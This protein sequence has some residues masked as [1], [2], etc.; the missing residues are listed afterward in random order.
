MKD[1]QIRLCTDNDYAS[2]FELLRQ[3]WNKQLNYEMLQSVYNNALKSDSQ[4]LIVCLVDNKVT[5]FCSLTIKNN[6]WQAGNLGHIDE[7]IV[8]KNHRRQGI[9]RKL[10][11]EI[12]KI[13]KENN[14]KRIEL[15]SAFHRKEAHQFYE[16]S[17]Y[18]N[19]AYLFSKAI[20]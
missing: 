2:V 15:D 3:L 13:A 12:T 14:C 8:D 18:E 16:N 11:D 19:R 17:G 1:L 5:G 10:M 9:G 7:L 4:K 6:L 20:T